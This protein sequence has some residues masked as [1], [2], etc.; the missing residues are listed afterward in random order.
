[1]SDFCGDGGNLYIYY[2][3]PSQLENIK[4]L[5]FHAPGG[6]GGLGGDGWQAGNAGVPGKGGEGGKGGRGKK[7]NGKNGIG[8]NVGKPGQSGN[9]GEVGNP[10]QK[11]KL[12]PE[13]TKIKIGEDRLVVA[14]LAVIDEEKAK[15]LDRQ[16]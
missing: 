7:E 3:N 8:G 13:P 6:E 2:T 9:P 10:G 12:I 5:N 4:E 15:E 11:G 16:L 14:A 1:L